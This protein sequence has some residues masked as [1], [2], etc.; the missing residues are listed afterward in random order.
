MYLTFVTSEI[1]IKL[2]NENQKIGDSLLKLNSEDIVIK[3]T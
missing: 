2:G 3:G 1:D